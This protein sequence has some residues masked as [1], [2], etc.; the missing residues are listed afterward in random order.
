MSTLH[1]IK[2][3]EQVNENTQVVHFKDGTPSLT[4]VSEGGALTSV[5]GSNTLTSMKINPI[6]N[7]YIKHRV[8]ALNEQAKEVRA[9]DEVII[10]HGEHKGKH[11]FVSLVQHPDSDK[12]YHIKSGNKESYGHFSDDQFFHKHLSEEAST[13]GGGAIAGA[14]VGPQGEPGVNRNREN[15]VKLIL[16]KMLQRKELN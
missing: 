10:S 6:I 7:A 16:D 9:G 12:K 15:A 4:V 5:C 13:V 14:G 11:G 2:I 1:L 3:I 8:Y